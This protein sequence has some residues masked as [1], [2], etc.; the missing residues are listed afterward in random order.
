MA[1][2]TTEI[3]AQIAKQQVNVDNAKVAVDSCQLALLELEKIELDNAR[4]AEQAI[5]D[6]LLNKKQ[7]AINAQE[8]ADV[9]AQEAVNIKADIIATVIK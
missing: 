8:V 7:Q 1:L 5:L 2:D 6:E 3:D 9:K 4:R